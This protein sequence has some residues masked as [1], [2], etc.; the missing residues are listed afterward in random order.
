MTKSEALVGS[1]PLWLVSVNNSGVQGTNPN[2]APTS[3]MPTISADGRNVA[4]YSTA[5]LVPEDTNTFADVYVRDVQAGI[6]KRV[7]IASNGD[8]ADGPSETA[9][10]SA[11][12][13]FVVLRSDAT[14]LV[15]GDTNNHTDFFV[16][17]LQTAIT[18][19]ESISTSSTQAN[20]S[21]TLASISADG[22]YIVFDSLASNLVPNDTNGR[23]DIFL[24]DRQNGVT[25]RE[26]IN[27]SGNQANETSFE[28]E[29]SADGRYIVFSSFASNLLVG[30]Q[31]PND[32][33]DAYDIFVRDRQ[34][35]TNRRVSVGSNGLQA[36]GGSQRPQINDSGTRIVFDSDA[37]NLVPEN[38]PLPFGSQYA[39]NVYMHDLTTNTTSLLSKSI[40]GSTGGNFH[41]NQP[42]ISGDGEFV[43]FTSSANDLVSGDSGII[44]EG[45]G[46]VFVREIV[47]DTTKRISLSN[48]GEEGNDNSYYP[49]IS[50]D[51]NYTVFAS[52]AS[53]FVTPDIN[54]YDIFLYQNSIPDTQPPIVMG[55]PDREANSHNWYNADVTIDWTAIDP[56]PSSATP[57]DPPNTTASTEGAN[58]TYT[59]G[60]SCD[61]D[62]NCAAGSLALSIDKTAPTITATITSAPNSSGWNK[63][64]VT[65]TFACTDLL[66]GIDFCPA[67]FTVSNDTASQTVSGSAIDKAGN[68]AN[69]SVVVKIDKTVPTITAFVVPASN[70]NGWNNNDVTVTFTCNDV[71][72]GIDS[73]SSPITVSG[74]ANN[75]AITGTAV[76]NAGNITTITVTLNIDKTLPTITTAVTPAP[77][78]K[79]WNNSNVTITL[80]CSDTLSG[81][82]TC[83]APITLTNERDG[84]VVSGTAVDNAGNSINVTQTIR[85]DKT[86][87]TVGAISFNTPGNQGVKTLNQTITVS[88][89]ANDV[90]SGI[91]GGEYF[92]DVDP[93]AGNG[94]PM[95]ISGLNITGTIGTNLTPGS[96]QIYVRSKDAAGNWSILSSRR[97]VV[98]PF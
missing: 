1:G 82:D 77:N 33:N 76:D 41:S 44:G 66:S 89:L 84:Q 55:S 98:L 49:S 29:I 57:T 79:G 50:F 5:R 54:G 97:L 93:G 80:T 11:N 62:N 6:T 72:S 63:D 96:H 4:F 91:D 67:P 52:Q 39:Q 48:N 53:N 95:T 27:L 43:V 2:Y 86:I 21:S 7:S 58:V 59:S 51:G 37:R 70:L 19:I 25:S 68:T 22:R 88:A 23:S 71:L 12:G 3:N 14:N 81:V 18:T 10:I 38:I 35:G 31:N 94:T 24:R 13:R 40:N 90:L 16:H 74:E 9:A 26:S 47:T 28:P 36:N 45:S 87:P 75:Q 73:C 15:T 8:Q 61:P 92:V 32:S 56:A 30:N 60:Q 65:V 34:T 85:I 46:D 64:E 17:D 20:N 69:A 42:A 83:S 78:A